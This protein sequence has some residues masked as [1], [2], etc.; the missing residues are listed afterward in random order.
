MGYDR[1]S[2]VSSFY[3]G[4]QSSFD[5]LNA[6]PASPSAGTYGQ[7]ERGRVDSFYDTGRAPRTSA[8]AHRNLSSAGYNRT[9]FFHTGREEP[10]KGGHDEENTPPKPDEAWDIY[11][12]FN[13]QGPRYST[14]FGR[15]DSGSYR[16]VPSPTP[17]L[18]HEE[19]AFGSSQV[20]MVTVPA[21][22]PEWRKDE[23]VGER[24]KMKK[25]DD[26]I[27]RTQNWR[28]WN[29]GERGLCGRYFTRKF[30]VFFV[31]FLCVAV[32]ITL[33]FT[34]PR[35]PSFEVNSNAPLTNASG[36]FNSSIPTEFSRVPAN[37]SF[38]AI[39]QLQADTNSNYLPLDIKNIHASVFDLDTSRQIGF[40]D[41]GHLKL[42][43][44]AFPLVNIP[45]NF[46]YVAS[47]DSDQTWA[48]WYNACRN[49]GNY[50]DG[51]RPPIKFR[52]I[53]AMDILGLVGSQSTSTTVDNAPCPIE[54]SLDSV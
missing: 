8:D 26:R 11:A 22:G 44:N 36:S 38:P 41:T 12:D 15:S 39:A 25:E 31:F 20:E 54:L 30:T 17:I 28:A 53:L 49:R 23:L 48:N 3:G 33:A 37:F 13:N 10:L 6:D 42:P 5:A 19:E 29:R 7:P 27:A 45:L 40:G 51:Q 34:I 18:K 4:R 32:G 1:R 50:A 14:T 47:N 52:L 46:S 35:V 43:A 2:A 21:L 16:Q 9:S 24:K